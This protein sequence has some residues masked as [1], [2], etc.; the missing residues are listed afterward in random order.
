[1]FKGSSLDRD[2]SGENMPLIT[3]ESHVQHLTIAQ[4]KL[5]LP[6]NTIRREML[7]LL[8]NHQVLILVGETGTGKTTQIPQYLYEA[9]WTAGGK[10][11]CCTQPRCIAATSVAARV[12]EEMG[13]RLGEEVGYSIRFEDCTHPDL[14]RIK[15]M[16]DGALFREA[17]GDPLLTRYSVIMI[18]EAHERTIYTD[19]VLALLKKYVN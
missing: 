19:L 2:A 15:Y 6:I 9:G 13:V 1:M 10:L 5:R 7:Y 14:T 17:M 3:F 16:T 18:D 12:A 11:V 8:E 4:Q